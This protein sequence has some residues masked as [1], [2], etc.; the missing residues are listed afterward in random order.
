MVDG[1]V[2]VVRGEAC[3]E[4]PPDVARFSVTVAARHEDRAETLTRLAQRHDAVRAI[5]DRYGDAVERRET[6]DL[7]VRPEL[8]R[9]GE[10]VIA[11]RASATTVVTVRD[12]GILGEMMVRLTA[13]EQVSVAGPWWELRPDH[14]A[15]RAVRHAAIADALAR[16]REYAE[17]LGAR[18]TGVV[19]ISETGLG[20]EP[21]V[22]R[23]VAYD[24]AATAAGPELG[25]D[26]QPQVVRAMVT[27]R[28]TLSQPTVL[29]SGRCE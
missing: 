24:L 22:A 16:A 4:V 27:A 17:A 14:P 21:L 8:A 28:F 12:V 20:V 19:E 9:A 5:V 3:R 11:Y 29:D 23:P 15:H 13:V 2:L 7:V 1:P 26:P 25:L 18:V 6:G 10:R